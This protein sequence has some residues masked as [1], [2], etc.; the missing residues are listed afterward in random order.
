M[1]LTPQLFALPPAFTSKIRHDDRGGE[2]SLHGTSSDVVSRPF[3]A[4]VSNA[5]VRPDLHLPPVTSDDSRIL[6]VELPLEQTGFITVRNLD[7]LM[8]Y[9]P[10]VVETAKAHGGGYVGVKLGVK[11]DTAGSEQADAV[12]LSPVLEFPSVEAAKTWIDSDEYRAIKP[13][14][15]ENS[16]GMV[17]M[18]AANMLPAGFDTSTF[19]AYLSTIKKFKSPEDKARFAEA[20]PPLLKA[21]NA[22]FGATMIARV[23]MRGDGSDAL[24]YSENCEDMHLAVLIGFPTYEGAVAYLSDPEFGIAQTQCR[25]DTMVGPLAVVKATSRADGP[26][27]QYSGVPHER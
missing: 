9:V 11:E 27:P 8:K 1:R 7:K 12:D 16:T 13:I 17:A 19:G 25:L 26:F 21:N 3:R 10:P 22:K 14:R 2:Q 5:D 6:P 20:Y 24:L 15:T 4:T 18:F 23:P